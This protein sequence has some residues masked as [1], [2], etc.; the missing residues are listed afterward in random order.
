MMSSRISRTSPSAGDRVH[1]DAPR[2]LRVAQDGGERLIQ[3]VRDRG[4]QLAD[5][6]HHVDVR[7]L[8]KVT[9]DLGF[10]AFAG[11]DIEMRQHGAAGR[12]VQPLDR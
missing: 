9:M 12:A 2:R 6:R 10:D 11:G 7:E 5:P 3:L 1:H 4:R 8:V